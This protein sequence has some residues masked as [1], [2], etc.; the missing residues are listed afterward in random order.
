MRVEVKEEKRQNDKAGRQSTCERREEEKEEGKKA[1]DR[2]K[3]IQD[4]YGIYT[5]VERAGNNTKD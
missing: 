2:M 4:G 5:A 3:R 1:E